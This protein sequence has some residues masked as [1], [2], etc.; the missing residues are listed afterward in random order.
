MLGHGLDADRDLAHAKID[1]LHA[2]RL[3]EAE[4]RVGHEVLVVARREITR[5]RPEEVE[6]L[7]LGTAG[8]EPSNCA[9][10]QRFRAE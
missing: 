2:V 9:A 1:R 4:E 10:G 3:R 6:L 8:M 7:A 5:Q